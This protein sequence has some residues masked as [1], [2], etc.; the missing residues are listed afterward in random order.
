MRNFHP[1]PPVL[2]LVLP[3]LFAGPS[4]LAQPALADLD[5]RVT[6][7]DLRPQVRIRDYENRTVEEYS[8][9]GNTYMLKITPNA[10][11]PYYLVDTDGSG[12][13]TWSRNRPNLSVPQWTLVSW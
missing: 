11:A 6:A 12:D 5:L 1:L 13:M 2:L 8:V 4:V 7:E 10:G 3:A 9:N